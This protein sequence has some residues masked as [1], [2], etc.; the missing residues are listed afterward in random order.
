MPLG[1]GAGAGSGFASPGFS[2]DLSGRFSV[3]PGPVVSVGSP[4]A[5]VVGLMELSVEGSAAL[6]AFGW[7]VADG[8]GSGDELATT[9]RGRDLLAADEELG[10]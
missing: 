9:L 10:C 6:G 5:L 3:A 7:P 8:V 4:S 2:A 1:V